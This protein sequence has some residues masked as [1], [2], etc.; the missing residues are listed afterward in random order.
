MLADGSTA[1][2]DSKIRS[3]VIYKVESMAAHALRCLAIAHKVQV[4][5]GSDPLVA[6]GKL[7]NMAVVCQ[8]VGSWSP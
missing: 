3:E 8:D 7:S 2:M 6:S 4:G 5:P 1:N